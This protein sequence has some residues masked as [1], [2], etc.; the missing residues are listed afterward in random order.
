M[1]LLFCLSFPLHNICDRA[2]TKLRYWSFIKFSFLD[3]PPRQPMSTGR[4]PRTL[5]TTWATT[6]PGQYTTNRISNVYICSGNSNGS[7]PPARTTT[8][9]PLTGLPAGSPS[10]TGGK[11]M[12]SHILIDRVWKDSTRTDSPSPF[13]FFNPQYTWTL[14]S[15]RLDL[16]KA[17]LTIFQGL[18]RRCDREQ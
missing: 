12:P 9:S 7:T 13:P 3:W 18:T 10:T 11:K 4:R 2:S 15:A 14:C 5:V 17:H 16:L 8:R 1:V 6:R